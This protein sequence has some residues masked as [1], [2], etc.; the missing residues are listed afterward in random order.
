MNFMTFFP[1]VTSAGRPNH[2]SLLCKVL[3]LLL[4]AVQYFIVGSEGP[5]PP[6][7]SFINSRNC[8]GF[9]SSSVANYITAPRAGLLISIFDVG[10]WGLKNSCRISI[11]ETQ[12][13]FS[14]LTIEIL[15]CTKKIKNLTC[16]VILP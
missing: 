10:W 3:S 5:W 1:V 12:M 15:V 13:M 4:C 9:A 2:G 8:G 14:V 7:R 6:Y 16:D 11:A